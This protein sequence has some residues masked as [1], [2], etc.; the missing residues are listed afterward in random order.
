MEK[1]NMDFLFSP[2]VFKQGWEFERTPP[3]VLCK[4]TQYSDMM[5]SS[6]CNAVRAAFSRTAI[7]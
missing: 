3:K 5:Q 4:A 7:L 2:N 6:H 1:R